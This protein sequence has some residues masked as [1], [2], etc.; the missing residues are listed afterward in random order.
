MDA[1]QG[2]FV[3]SSVTVQRRPAP[4]KT[5]VLGKVCVGPLT[6]YLLIV[7]KSGITLLIKFRLFI[8]IDQS[9]TLISKRFSETTGR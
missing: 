3:E 1:S 8:P 7:F 5:G 6:T 2:S 4:N 9:Y